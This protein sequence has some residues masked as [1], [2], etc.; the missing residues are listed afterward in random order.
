MRLSPAWR[1]LFLLFG[2]RQSNSF[3]ELGDGV[4]RLR[5]GLLFDERFPTADV[6]G[7]VQRPWPWWRGIG[8]R[9]DFRGHVSLIGGYGRVSEVR[10]RNKRRVSGLLP[11]SGRWLSCDR[12]SISLQDPAAFQ[13]ALQSRISPP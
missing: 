5:F 11:L 1:P 7:V 8:W 3:A 6:I 13:V 2:A 10:L 9:T 12:I 4:L